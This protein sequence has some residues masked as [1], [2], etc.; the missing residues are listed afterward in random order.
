MAEGGRSVLDIV[1]TLNSEGIP[2]P[3]GK[4]WSKTAVHTMLRNETYTR[5]LWCG[6]SRPKTRQNPIRVE[7]AFPAIV[8]KGTFENV[9]ASAG[10][11]CSCK[12]EPT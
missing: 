8:P 6:A 9:A 1:K 10:V 5:A 2:S 3:R 11:P 7:D 12:G 4:R